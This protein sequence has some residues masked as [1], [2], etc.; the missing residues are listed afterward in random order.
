M[1][2]TTTL[3]RQY[4]PGDGSNHNFPF[5]FKFFNNSQ[6]YVFVIDQ[7]G[8][9]TGQTLN[10]DYTLSGALS[11][12]GGLVVMSVAPPATSQVLV[13]RIIPVDQPTSIRNQGAF[14][15]AI[16]ED[17]FDRLTMIVQQA[18]YGAVNSLK[19]SISGS[20]WDFQNIRGENA[21]DPV[22]DQ[23][24]A[25]K[26]SVEAYVAS[27]LA[28]GQ[29]PVNN[30]ANV[31]YLD[32]DGGAKVVQDLSNKTN[33][34]MGGNLIGWIRNYVGAV[35]TTV[36]K[37]IQRQPVIDVFD[38]MTEAQIADVRGASVLDHTVA[39][40]NAFAEAFANLPS[41][42]RFGKG[43]FNRASWPNLAKKGLTIRGAGIR[44]TVL[45]C[46][47][48]GV[49]FNFDAFASGSPTDPFIS[50]CNVKD[51]TFEGNATVTRIVRTQGLALHSWK[52]VNAR[53]AE[54][55]AGIGF[56]LL[57]TQLGEFTGIRC[58]VDF[59]PM[60]SKPFIGIRIDEGR[61][62]TVS[63]GNSSNNTFKNCYFDGMSFGGRLDRADQNLF[64][65]GA[66]QSCTTYGLLVGVASRYNTLIG[67]G[68]E[69]VAATG[70][71]ITDAGI[72]TQYHNCYASNKTILQGRQCRI[73]G[74]YHE[75]IFVDAGTFGNT[76]QDVTLRHWNTGKPAFTNNGAMTTYKN[77]YDAK[78]AAFI[79]PKKARTGITLPASGTGWVNP[80]GQYVSVAV[81]GGSGVTTRIGDGLG[82]YWTTNSGSPTTHLLR[83]GD[84]IEVS[85]SGAPTISYIT[86]NGL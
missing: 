49:A 28:T 1:T 9:P 86:H 41:I 16:H 55:T 5:N 51:L 8:I 3:D 6:I 25:T 62:A 61:R 75:S 10:V 23:D 29:G 4:F 77:L 73:T 66:F 65:G 32:P 18:I 33:Y 46:T 2:V 63:I 24:V 22:N 76:I 79:F 48:S 85:Y 45:K 74:G 52:N 57:G 34:L 56:E 81:Q 47:G 69:N 70:G 35:G 50:Q 11:P 67:T 17:V 37:W 12:S 84:V 44:S 53:E 30:A 31:I 71:D 80:T 15:P 64:L 36:S 54:P 38:F 60:T 72:Q 58:S 82:D 39:I 42:V 27:I 68:F 13:Q 14:F 26:K 19:K 20:A 43:K 21:A 59:N 83:P 40:D 78:L 7:A